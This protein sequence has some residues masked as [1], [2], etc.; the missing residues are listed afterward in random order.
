MKQL[1]SVATCLLLTVAAPGLASGADSAP[2][3]D[4]ATL[5]GPTA[6]APAYETA[7]AAGH[8]VLDALEMKGV[9]GTG[10]GTDFACGFMSGAGLV[11]TLSGVAS[12]VGVTL[13]VGGVL[14]SLFF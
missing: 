14:C 12:P 4:P 11:M 2:S 8:T 6:S 1:A 13:G 10:A 3:L 9:A 7:Y 5:S